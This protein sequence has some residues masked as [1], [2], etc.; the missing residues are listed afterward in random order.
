LELLRSYIITRSLHSLER[1]CW[2]SK[3]GC[4]FSGV[5]QDLARADG[6]SLKSIS[7][8]TLQTRPQSRHTPTCQVVP[9]YPL[10]QL[11]GA[12]SHEVTSSPIPSH[13]L[14]LFCPLSV[15]FLHPLVLQ[16]LVLQR[17]LVHLPLLSLLATP[18]NQRPIHT[19][20]QNSMPFPMLW[21][22]QGDTTRAALTR[23]TWH[24]FW[25]RLRPGK[26]EQT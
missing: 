3:R 17:H 21:A 16:P 23:P 18:C 13:N 9:L 22:T 6:L 11:L 14:S 1:G 25:C 26:Q 15:L 20:C 10:P 24:H 5:R 12:L 8:Q 2:K 7:A 19:D 4:C